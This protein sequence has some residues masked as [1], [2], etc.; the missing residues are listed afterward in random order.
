[1]KRLTE[2]FV[3]TPILA[4]LVS[5]SGD[6]KI[7]SMPK[8]VSGNAD[9]VHA[10]GQWKRTEGNTSAVLSRINTVDIRCYRASL[11]CTEIIALLSTTNDYPKGYPKGSTLFIDQLEY[12][13]V[14]WSNEAVEARHEAMAGDL[15]LRIYVKDQAAHRNWRET[16]ARGHLNADPKFFAHYE[17]Q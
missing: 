16:K 7:E 15:D 2:F 13:V 9:Y 12:D 4:L 6:D 11:T 5:C 14:V 3:C 10:K 8:Y 1:M 17:L